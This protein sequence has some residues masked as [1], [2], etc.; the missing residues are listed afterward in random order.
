M[1]NIPQINIKVAPQGG[2]V[3][4]QGNTQTTIQSDSYRPDNSI[5]NT[6]ISQK[7]QGDIALAAQNAESFRQIPNAVLKSRE[8]AIA[9]AANCRAAKEAADRSAKEALELDG[10]RKAAQYYTS[11]KSLLDP[12]LSPEDKLIHENNVKTLETDAFLYG[13]E[14]QRKLYDDEE[15]DILTK[16][17]IPFIDK[18]SSKLQQEYATTGVTGAQAFLAAGR[19]GKKLFRATDGTSTLVDDPEWAG[20]SGLDPRVSALVFQGLGS[21]FNDLQTG[22]EKQADIE[23]KGQQIE[24]K[25]TENTILYN[26][27]T[28]NKPIQP[29]E[30]FDMS[31]DERRT[32]ATEAGVTISAYNAETSRISATTPS[33]AKPPSKEERN[34]LVQQYAPQINQSVTQTM[35]KNGTPMKYNPNQI[36]SSASVLVAPSTKDWLGNVKP[37]DGREAQKLGVMANRF[38]P[39][40]N[41]YLQS[42]NNPDEAFNKA[43]TTLGL[44]PKKIPSTGSINLQNPDASPS[45]WGIYLNRFR[46]KILTDYNTRQGLQALQFEYNKI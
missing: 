44:D 23:F 28:G 33:P 27:A 9:E 19:N 4:N 14:K 41:Q 32:A 11:K 12:T 3:S 43:V 37:N 24:G 36:G 34:I 10:K 17:A 1:S 25:Q 21:T 39:L 42:T 38:E 8:I 35:L 20:L 18:F 6:A 40:F 30:K 29:V 13:D 7:M 15:K 22:R 31:Q 46:S 2:N 26:T 45:D 5:F 16:Q